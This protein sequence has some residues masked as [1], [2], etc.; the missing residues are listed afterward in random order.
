MALTSKITAIANAVRGKTGGS[1]VMTLPQIASEI[2][3]KLSGNCK[4][5]S[6][7]LS[8]AQTSTFDVT[9]EVAE[10]AA[11]VN[12]TTL[13]AAFIPLGIYGNDSSVSYRRFV[14]ISNSLMF[15]SSGNEEY[16]ICMRSAEGSTSSGAYTTKPLNDTT[17]V[18]M[19]VSSNGVLSVVSDS[20]KPYPAGDYLVMYGWE[21]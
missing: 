15:N 9:G 10:L 14:L 8:Q 1:A 5:F 17:N 12:D 3:N 13:W 19:R 4:C 21:P 16:G 2:A 18:I 11:H 20:T 7:T 6:Y